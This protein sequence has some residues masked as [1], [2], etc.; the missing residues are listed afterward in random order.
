MDTND[1]GNKKFN[2]EQ[3]VNEGFSGE[4]IAENYNPSLGKLKPEEEIDQD[5]NHKLVRRADLSD[6]QSGRSWNENES[7]SRGVEDENTTQKMVEHKDRNS[8]IATNRY[9]NAHPDNHTDRGN[10]KLDE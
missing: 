4:N 3:Q 7:L 2:N 5:G 9:P 1:L 10:I 6:E 8:D